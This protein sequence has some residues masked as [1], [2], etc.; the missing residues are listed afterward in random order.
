MKHEVAEKGIVA[1]RRS[2]NSGGLA[3]ASL[4]ALANDSDSNSSN[5]CHDSDFK[6]ERIY[7][8]KKQRES[9]AAAEEGGLRG[10]RGSHSKRS[11]H[12]SIPRHSNSHLRQLHVQPR[13]PV[14]DIIS[15]DPSA[16]P[17]LQ[18]ISARQP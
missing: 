11:S 15:Y 3:L 1:L 14:K 7:K 13:T 4:N 10:A 2:R 5:S 17:S 6:E 8:E 9:L 16:P 12:N 18:T